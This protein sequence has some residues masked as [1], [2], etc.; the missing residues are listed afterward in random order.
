MRSGFVAVALVIAAGQP[1]LAQA[2]AQPSLILDCAAFPKSMDEAALVKRFGRENVVSAVLDGA[3]GSTERGT[4]LYPKDPARRLEVYWHDADK[5][6]RPSSFA[7][8]GRSEWLVR[9]PGT[10][11]PTIGL[12]AS[13]AE[14]EEANER[15]FTLTGF[16]WDMGGYASG[17]KGG[18]LDAMPGGC[19]VTVRFNPDPKARDRDVA[20]VSGDKQFGS[21]APGIRAVKPVVSVLTLDWPE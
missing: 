3:E 14:V 11:R 4:V 19:F 18:R 20:K 6:R 8:K 21:A 15:P 2:P 10:A 17:W 9:G 5:R 1:A 16:G 13:V 7:V 12:R